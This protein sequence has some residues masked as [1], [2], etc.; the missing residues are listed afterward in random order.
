MCAF[1]DNQWYVESDIDLVSKYVKILHSYFFL[2]YCLFMS[3]IIITRFYKILIFWYNS[4]GKLP[5][6]Y[7]TNKLKLKFQYQAMNVNPLT[8]E[9]PCSDAKKRSN[10]VHRFTDRVVLVL[11]KAKLFQIRD[12]YTTGLVV[13]WPTCC[14][15]TWVT[16]REVR[17]NIWNRNLARKQLLAYI[18]QEG[19]LFTWVYNTTYDNYLPSFFL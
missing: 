13:L 6:L 8:C 2:Y 5:F 18:S 16:S 17:V 19:R 10:I 12:Y 11:A 3:S 14:L 4:H 7:E 9:K 1:Y 15:Y